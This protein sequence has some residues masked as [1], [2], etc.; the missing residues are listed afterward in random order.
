MEKRTR[1]PYHKFSPL[2]LIHKLY[3]NAYIHMLKNKHCDFFFLI[4]AFNLYRK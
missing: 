3:L 2:F 4:V 1:N